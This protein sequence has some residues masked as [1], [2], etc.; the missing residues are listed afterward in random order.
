MATV[1]GGMPAH[2]DI[3]RGPA[4]GWSP[5]GLWCTQVIGFSSEWALSNTERSCA[6]QEMLGIKASVIWQHNLNDCAA[7]ASPDSHSSAMQH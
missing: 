7:Q 1:R 5:Q 4:W 6:R 3:C 2:L